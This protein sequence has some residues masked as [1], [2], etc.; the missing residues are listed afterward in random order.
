[1]VPDVDFLGLKNLD[2]RVLARAVLAANP[3]RRITL[4]QMR[5]IWDAVVNEVFSFEC[6]CAREA[7]LYEVTICRSSA[8]MS[9]MTDL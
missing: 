5:L 3:K 9:P 6:G 7:K 8:Q 1:M 4:S 2:F